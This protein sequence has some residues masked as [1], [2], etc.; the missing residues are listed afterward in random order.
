MARCR[1]FAFAPQKNVAQTLPACERSPAYQ[2]LCDDV[3]RLALRRRVINRKQCRL[4]A[5]QFLDTRTQQ[6]PVRLL[7]G[8][9]PPEVE[10]SRLLD[11]A[12]NA[13]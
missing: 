1:A 3:L 6:G 2:Q 11:L 5:E 7:N 13:L 12:A 9:M 8:E 4:A 10:Q